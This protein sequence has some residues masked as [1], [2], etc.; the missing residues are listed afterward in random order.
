MFSSI[1]SQNP[2]SLSINNLAYLIRVLIFATIV[3]LISWH[4]L[5]Y[6]G[7]A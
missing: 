7:L 2:L 6:P 4:T 5:E 1:L 3:Y